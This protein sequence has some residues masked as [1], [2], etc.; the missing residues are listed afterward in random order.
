MRSRRRKVLATACVLSSFA[1]TPAFGEDTP[2]PAAESAPAKEPEKK[3]SLS[4]M[5][6]DEQDGAFDMSTWLLKKKGFLPVPIIITEPAVGY[7]GGIAAVFFSQSI[8]E[9]IEQAKKTGHRTPPDI[10]VLAAAKTENGTNFIGGGG[11]VSFLDDRWRYRGFV[12]HGDVHLDFYGGGEILDKDYK[13]AYE[14]NGWFSYQQALYRLGES[15]NFV[16]ARW[17]YMDLDSSFGAP[18]PNLPEQSFGMRNSGIG[19]SFEHDS[20]DNTFTPSKGALAVVEA[21]FYDPNWGSDSRF[22]AY[23]AHVFAYTPVGKTLVLGGRLDGRAARGDV[24]FYMQPFLDM[25]GMAAARYQDQ[26]TALAEVEARWSV[27][28]RWGLIGFVGAGRAWGNKLSFDEATSE[29]SK[30][31]GFRYQVARLLGLWAGI[32]YAWGPDGQQAFYIQMG[33]AWR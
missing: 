33:N 20:R 6:F 12:G 1:V 25:R 21:M 29:V 5:F 27:T 23:R 24:P 28:P 4:S 15:D 14:L 8:E 11:M 18:R 3:E 22:Q 32:D 17:L 19:T 7:G 31:V 30:G 9:A 10:Y 2:E 13:I 16:S 26:N